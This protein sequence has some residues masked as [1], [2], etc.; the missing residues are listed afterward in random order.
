MNFP[1]GQHDDQV[2][3]LTQYLEWLRVSKRDKAGIRSL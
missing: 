1:G 3:A 2:D